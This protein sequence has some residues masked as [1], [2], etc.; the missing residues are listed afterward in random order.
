MRPFTTTFYSYKGGVGRSILAANC[1]IALSRRG[2]TLLWDLD[3]E[4][5]GLH[6]VNDLRT[7]AGVSTGFF[8]WLIDWQKNQRRPLGAAD[9][10]A[11]HKA[12]ARTPFTNLSLLPAHGDQ[13]DAAALYQTIDWVKALDQGRER[14]G[15]ILDHFGAQG[16]AHVVIDSRT[17]IT[18]LGGLLAG[19]LPQATV[20]VGGFGAQNTGGLAN[21]WHALKRDDQEMKQLRE[22]KPAPT[23]LLV[24]SPIPQGDND[25]ASITTGK[26][27][28]QKA[29][30]VELRDILEVPFDRTLLFSESLLISQPERAV[31]QAYEGIVAR[32]ST[33][34][35]DFVAQS[36]AAQQNDAERHALLPSGRGKRRDGGDS[37]AEQGRRFEDRVAHLLR[38]LGYAV[39]GEQ[40]YDDNRVDLTARQSSG[41]EENTYFVECKD[42]EKAVRKD[43]IEKLEVWLTKPQAK[44]ANARGMVVAR[45]FS[46]DALAYAKNAQILTFTPQELERRLVDFAPHLTR[47][48]TGFEQGQL[49]SSYVTQRA[50]ALPLEHLASEQ[51]A[52]PIEDLL[53]H[54]IAWAEGRGSRL[55]V[56]LGDYG[57]GK[58]AFTQRL[59]YALALRAREDAS[60]P[61]PLLI[62]LRDV[63]NKATLEEVLE[64]HWKA[65]APA[66]RPVSAQVFLHLIAQGRVVLLLDSFDEMGIAQAGRNVVEQFRAMVRLTMEAGDSQAERPAAGNRVLV[67]C[68]EQFF[69]DHAQVLSAAKG[70]TDRIAPL[71]QVARGFDGTLDVLA[72]FTAAQISEFLLKRLGAQDAAKAETFIANARL[73]P[74]TDRP[75]LLDMIVKSL[76]D[77]MAAQQGGTVLSPGALYQIYTNDWLDNFKPVERQ[78]SSEQLRAILDHLAFILWNRGGNRIHYADL[79]ALLQKEEVLRQGMDAVQLDVELRTAAFL[80]RTPDGLYGFSHRSFLEYFYARRIHG[81]LHAGEAVRETAR[82]LDGAHLN[83]E[84]C[85]FVHDLLG[86][87]WEVVRGAL[88]GLL[89][90][91]EGVP[92]ASLTVRVNALLLGYHL[93]MGASGEWD[94]DGGFSRNTGETSATMA[95]FL[96]RQAQLAGANLANLR[97]PFLALPAANLRG[98]TLTRTDFSDALLEGADLREAQARHIV[99]RNA[100]LTRSDWRGAKADFAQARGSGIGNVALQPTVFAHAN[101]AHSTW[102]GAQL[103]F[104]DLREA[105]CT[106]TDFRRARMADATVPALRANALFAGASARS[107]YLVPA[108]L[109]ARPFPPTHP[110]SLPANAQAHFDF[111]HTDTIN[112]AA[113]SPDGARIATASSKNNTACLWDAAS[114]ALLL[115][116]SGHRES[117][118][119]AGFSPDGA[120]IVTASDDKTARLW[121]AAS[122]ALLLTLSGHGESVRSAAFSP[123]SPTHSA[124]IVTASDDHT[125]RLWDAASGTLLLTLSMHGRSVNSAAFS[126]DGARIVTASNDKTARLWDAESGAL[127]LTLSGHGQSVRSAAFS[128]NGA[129]IVTASADNTARLWDAESG[130]SL[131]TLQGHVNS[132]SSA[133]FSPDGTCIVSASDDYTA[134]LWDADT[135]TLIPTLLNYGN[136]VYRAAFSPDGARIVTA[137]DDCTARLWDAAFG[138]HLLTLSGHSD[139]VV[140]AAFSPDGA[141]IITASGDHT[142]H[143]WDAATGA[144]LFALQ[145]HGKLLHDA[146]FSQDGSRIITASADKTARVWDAASGVLLLTLSGHGGSVVSAAFSPDGA[147]AVTASNDNTARVW[148]TASGALL[149]TLQGHR[150]SVNVAAFSPDGTRIVTALSNHTVLLWDAAT[151]APIRTRQQE[152]AGPVLRAAF[153]PDGARIVTASTDKTARLWD[154]ATGALL[155]TLRGHRNHVFSAAFSPDGARIVTASGDNTA[156]LWDAASGA[157]LLQIAHVRSGMGWAV[158][159]ESPQVGESATAVRPP[160]WRGRGA[161]LGLIRYTDPEDKPPKGKSGEGWIPTEWFAEDLPELR[162]AD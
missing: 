109:R 145:G 106:A 18:D 9:L 143:L 5:P 23:L 10:K 147:R 89:A 16:Y 25:L 72:P 75:Q 157:P 153:S 28:W 66:Q 156:R 47:L 73:Q 101:L 48:V 2:K 26:A 31:A 97:L 3:V 117:V 43:I 53:A 99:L 111:G 83:A 146:A 91:V 54:G 61:I 103:G 71:V 36:E 77:L 158:L 4:A 7:E 30:G 34:A 81:A 150:S 21:A 112:W 121:D 131:L 162:A 40:T 70:Q 125:A 64:A 152:H 46:P 118:R 24:A 130:A 49:V 154:A 69:A 82:A 27:L 95:R 93:A 65:Q 86:G 138:A 133:A 20:F 57:T 114:G 148:D 134:R 90:P 33:L 105:D 128:P 60:L 129:R 44:A 87:K 63:S 159:D 94:A 15:E 35:D 58:T 1:A 135:G 11:L 160:R 12:V 108:A 14:F 45:G 74:L 59:A 98:A 137:S 88:Q 96:P 51:A 123:A 116:L 38:L 78:S 142:A 120:R 119:S 8:D 115:T 29:F 104:A 13:A 140:S 136:W 151:G 132:V 139:F 6:R 126:P 122:G 85:N 149:L 110:R 113:F 102:V 79:A 56:L 41:L 84:V 50:T 141:R 68:R 39:T 76:P 67:T 55:W 107:E 92:L 42:H 62:N 17:G 144:K 155:F 22:G 19:I 32:L 124:R 80:S 127:L 52:T 37:T 161:A 100:D